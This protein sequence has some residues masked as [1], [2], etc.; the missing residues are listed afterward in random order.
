MLEQTLV[1][2]IFAPLLHSAENCAPAT[3][4][5]TFRIGNIAPSRFPRSNVLMDSSRWSFLCSTLRYMLRSCHCKFDISYLQYFT[6]TD[7]VHPD[8]WPFVCTKLGDVDS[9]SWGRVFPTGKQALEAWIRCT[10]AVRY[11][12][13]ST[14]GPAP[15]ALY[16]GESFRALPAWLG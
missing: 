9:A 5:A 3:E 14:A 2:R 16:L 4:V 15:W 13:A 12:S 10:Q 1:V 7:A 6:G 8:H 11:S